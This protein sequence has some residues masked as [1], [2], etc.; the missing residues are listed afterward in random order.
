[1]MRACLTHDSFVGEQ[2]VELRSVFLLAYEPADVVRHHCH[3]DL[4]RPIFDQWRDFLERKTSPA[5]RID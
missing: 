1:M 5:L 2:F 3:K 4:R